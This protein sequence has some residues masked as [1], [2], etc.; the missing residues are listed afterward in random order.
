MLYGVLPQGVEQ[1]LCPAAS[2][3]IPSMAGSALGELSSVS[4]YAYRRDGLG[5]LFGDCRVFLLYGHDRSS[6]VEGMAAEE[7]CFFLTGLGYSIHTGNFRYLA[8]WDAVR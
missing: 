1:K 3:D 6:A 8:I 7:L 5:F 4:S 2:A